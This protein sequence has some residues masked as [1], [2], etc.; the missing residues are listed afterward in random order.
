MSFHNYLKKKLLRNLKH[1]SC[2]TGGCKT[3]SEKWSFA[4]FNENL[5][6][7]ANSLALRLYQH[8]LVLPVNLERSVS[9]DSV[10]AFPGWYFMQDFVSIKR[11]KWV[12]G[13]LG[14][15]V[16]EEGRRG[17]SE[18]F[19]KL[20]VSLLLK[21]GWIIVQSLHIVTISAV[22]NMDF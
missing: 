12:R 17:D 13:Y 9:S 21:Q 11:L 2:K 22:L 15:R 7:T 10:A 16:P 18:G 8:W 1:C 19:G 4:H 14:T 6:F 5:M 3:N 20:F